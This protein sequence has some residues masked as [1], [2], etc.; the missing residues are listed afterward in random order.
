MFLPFQDRETVCSNARV[1]VLRDNRN[2]VLADLPNEMKIALPLLTNTYT[3]TLNI[4]T[5]AL[6]P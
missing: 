1:P 4:N 6:H 5:D 3:H 2:R